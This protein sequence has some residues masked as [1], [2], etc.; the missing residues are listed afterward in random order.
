M[1]LLDDNNR[2]EQEIESAAVRYTY[3]TFYLFVILSSLTGDTLIL[4][5]S[6][7]YKAF[8]LHRVIVVIIQHIA[9]CDLLVTLT[10]VVPICISAIAT[11]WVLGDF[12]CY[13]VTYTTYYYNAVGVLLISAMTSFKLLLLKYPLRVGSTSTSTAHTLCGSCWIVVVLSVAVLL[14]DWRDVYFSRETYKCTYGFS[15]DIWRFLRPLIAFV[16]ILAPTCLVITTSVYILV[17]AKAVAK[18]GRES[19]KW[20]GIMTTVLTATVFCVSILPY[21]VYRVRESVISGD[22]NNS[23]VS[24]AHFNR[25]TI[26]FFCLNTISNF[27]IYSLT[28]PSFRSFVLTRIRLVHQLVFNKQ[29]STEHGGTE[30]RTGYLEDNTTQ[31][32]PA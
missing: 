31:Q 17:K 20:Q 10:Y 16:F 7:K 4:L 14:I 28:V 21:F 24:F 15:S 1:T 12:L 8:R 5:A 26:S 2:T 25:V 18:R 27:Y 6:I 29:P 9:V 23:S 32:T 3:I 30:T 11:R 22:K 19:L 13:V